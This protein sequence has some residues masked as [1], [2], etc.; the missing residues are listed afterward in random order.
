MTEDQSYQM[1]VEDPLTLERIREVEE[2]LDMARNSMMQ[3]IRL[4]HWYKV[5]QMRQFPEIDLS[6]VR[7]A[8][9][10]KDHTAGRYLGDAQN[11]VKKIRRGTYLKWKIKFNPKAEQLE[12]ERRRLQRQH[13]IERFT[14]F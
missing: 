3:S 8:I 14:N 1:M 4:Q 11:A 10:K 13:K 2:I 5:I 7:R 6:N 9:I 12:A